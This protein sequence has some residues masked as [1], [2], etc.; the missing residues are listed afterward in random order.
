MAVLALTALLVVW[1]PFGGDAGPVGQPRADATSLKA[2]NAPSAHSI[3]TAGFAGDAVGGGARLEIVAGKPQRQRKTRPWHDET[4]YFPGASVGDSPSTLEF[5]FSETLVKQCLRGHFDEAVK[6]LPLSFAPGLNP[7]EFLVTGDYNSDWFAYKR[8]SNYW[9]LKYW[10]DIRPSLVRT[11]Q[12]VFG[13]AQQFESC[14]IVGNSGNLLK[15]SH[16]ED[17]DRHQRVFR[18][19]LAPAGGMYTDFVGSQT[20]FRIFNNKQSRTMARGGVVR[21]DTAN[22]PVEAIPR[23][24][25]ATLV[26]GR[27]L[28]KELADRL[29]QMRRM[30]DQ[31]DVL[32]TNKL[33]LMDHRFLDFSNEIL[34]QFKRCTEIRSGEHMTGK[35]HSATSGM[36][37]VLGALHMCKHVTTYGIGERESSFLR[38]HFHYY[39]DNERGFAEH[40]RAE[41]KAKNV[42]YT[43]FGHANFI[44]HSFDGE[45]G[46]LEALAKAGILRHCT[47]R[48]C[49]GR[50][51]PWRSESSGVETL[52]H[53]G[54]RISDAPTPQSFHF[55]EELQGICRRRAFADAVTKL[56]LS[57]PLG[58]DPQGLVLT[59]DSDSGFL[60]V[61]DDLA[62]LWPKLK[63]EMVHSKRDVFGDAALYESCA[64][65]GSSSGLLKASHGREIDKHDVVFRFGQAPAGEPYADHVGS[66]THFRILGNTA[67][68]TMSHAVQMQQTGEQHEVA[69]EV[70]N[71]TL[72][73]Y[74]CSADD[75]E[76][77]FEE[78][79]RSL[80]KRPQ[81]QKV[82]IMDK[83]F[84]LHAAGV[85]DAFLSCE[86]VR[87]QRKNHS[88]N[89]RASSY[90][91]GELVLTLGAMHLC[92]HVSVY[93]VAERQSSFVRHHAKYYQ[94]SPLSESQP[95]EV[96]RLLLTALADA[97]LLRH[98][99]W[100]GC[101]GKT[102]RG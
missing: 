46:F 98:C 75:V 57:L 59:Q 66:T 70:D 90:P 24:E 61:D 55:S 16:G 36:T 18:F 71:A 56:P 72:I 68:K 78:L 97:G 15:S 38:R 83:R 53:E 3:G 7:Q 33:A 84:F 91:S 81:K 23:D 67:F 52:E 5:D 102:L 6:L 17:I 13:T 87:Y 30:M 19:N 65:V 85:L 77:R 82:T 32:R 76:S 100:E 92:K 93:G 44:A 43:G 25:N 28:I 47:D 99:S 54:A 35:N 37:V 34:M 10:Q 94:S 63:A 41:M 79:W 21:L 73:L 9:I 31:D 42:S 88:V 40:F 80:A 50:E 12:D 69:P 49:Q 29:K 62:P 96:E 4:L 86:A 74:R 1:G 20:H 60:K 51:L 14:A 48:G 89:E 95:P 101:R 8:S 45:T 2:E 39:R 27:F 22:S 26:I 64:V 58:M 11:K